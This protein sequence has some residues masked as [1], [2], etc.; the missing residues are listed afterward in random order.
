MQKDHM[1]NW[2]LDDGHNFII[3]LTSGLQFCYVIC[4]VTEE[5]D[6][7]GADYAGDT[8]SKGQVPARAAGVPGAE[9]WFIP[10]GISQDSQ[11][12]NLLYYDDYNVI[13]Q[14]FRAVSEPD[15]RIFDKI[16]SQ[17]TLPQFGKDFGPPGLTAAYGWKFTGRD[18]P[19]E[20]PTRKG[21][22]FVLPG[23][24]IQMAY[25]NPQDFIV[26]VFIKY[27]VNKIQQ[28]VWDPRDPVGKAKIIGQL[29]HRIPRLFYTPELAGY[30]YEEQYRRPTFKD[31]PPIQWN[32]VTASYLDPKTQ[33]SVVIL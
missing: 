28:G 9:D 12:R 26:N 1:D 16:P 25:A 21:M 4:S 3:K 23:I 24:N 27:Y 5:Y 17:S 19:L 15:I 33:K 18:S 13:W 6:Y 20:F 7:T 22:L 2:R 8:S 29:Q 31:V 32:G 14:V 11:D 30:Q 10:K